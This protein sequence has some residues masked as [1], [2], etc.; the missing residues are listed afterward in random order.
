MWN[1]VGCG[2]REGGLLKSHAFWKIPARWQ[3][4]QRAN[5]VLSKIRCCG[6]RLCL[7]S[8][9]KVK[10]NSW[11]DISKVRISTPVLERFSCWVTTCFHSS[12]TP[13][14]YKTWSVSSVSPATGRRRRA[15]R[16]LGASGR[17]RW[18]NYWI[19]II[20]LQSNALYFF[21]SGRIW[22]AQERDV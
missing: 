3:Q 11:W 15:R 13:N 7:S 21:H 12:D 9:S 19:K 10:V 6:F 16:T 22:T 2:R 20:L 5:L 4:H 8:S 14:F 17:Q 18:T 1:K